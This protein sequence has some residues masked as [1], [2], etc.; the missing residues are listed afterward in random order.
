MTIALSLDDRTID[1]VTT[2]F[3][4]GPRYIFK[5]I[6]IYMVGKDNL[7]DR[8]FGSREESQVVGFFVFSHIQMMGYFRLS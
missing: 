4:V 1:R 8:I 5:Y 2:V 6:D 3:S 7:I